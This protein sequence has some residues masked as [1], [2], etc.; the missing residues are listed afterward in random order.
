MKNISTSVVTLCRVDMSVVKHPDKIRDMLLR[1]EKEN[2]YAEENG[3]L[4]VF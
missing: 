2:L 4:V 3:W 1:R